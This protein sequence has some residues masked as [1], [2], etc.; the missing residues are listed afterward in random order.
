M[1]DG[2]HLLTGKRWVHVDGDDTEEGAIYHNA[3]ANMTP[4]RRLREY[5]EF[6]NDG[7]VRKLATGADDSAQEIDSAHWVRN[8]EKISFRFA[9]ADAHGACE[10]QVIEQSANRIVVRRR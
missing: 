6:D 3:E 9:S 2:S 8:A 1:V 10:Y 4:S 5:L 7:T